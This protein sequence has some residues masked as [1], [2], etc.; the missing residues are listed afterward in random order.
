MWKVF[1]STKHM[2][3]YTLWGASPILWCKNSSH[4]DWHKKWMNH[5]KWLSYPGVHHIIWW[6][7]TASE[8]AIQ[9]G[10]RNH[11]VTA[12]ALDVQM[13]PLQGI[14]GK[15]VAH[16]FCAGTIYYIVTIQWSCRYLLGWGKCYKSETA[17][18]ILKIMN[19][20]W[21]DNALLRPSF[22]AYDDACNLLWHIVTE[23]P[24]SEWLKTIV[25]AWHYIGHCAT[26]VLCWLWCNL[27]PTDGSQP[28][29]MPMDRPTPTPKQLN[30]L[31]NSFEAE[32][33]QMMDVNFDFFMHVLFLLFKEMTEEQIAKKEH[34]LLDEFWDTVDAL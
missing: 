14:P 9:G 19:K 8:E 26:D 2:W 1:S 3:Y 4:I 34:E 20:M 32:L 12:P 15:N 30:S 10:V 13:P 22:M 16:T 7:H 21:T 29:L 25:D 27:A 6:Q 17:P 31:L 28:D 24:H 18:Q 5:F 33:S 11:D 23:D